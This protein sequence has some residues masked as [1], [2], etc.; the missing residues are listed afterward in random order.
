MAYEEYKDSGKTLG[1]VLYQLSLL[2]IPLYIVESLKMITSGELK[3][4]DRP[5]A[6]Y[7][8]NEYNNPIF[9]FR[10]PYDRYNDLKQDPLFT[11]MVSVDFGATFE[12]DCWFSFINPYAQPDWLKGHEYYIL[13]QN[14][15]KVGDD[16][17]PVND[18][19]VT[20]DKSVIQRNEPVESDSDYSR[21][22]L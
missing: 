15:N 12:T 1:K 7:K 11:V 19:A 3:Y 20:V 10:T 14:G 2:G 17:L 4:G 5:F 16:L 22:W 6:S 13:D 21:R 8:W 18:L 9:F